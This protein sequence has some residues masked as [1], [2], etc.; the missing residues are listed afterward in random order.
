MASEAALVKR[1]Q[2]LHNSA[3]PDK[4]GAA[5][6]RRSS[7]ARVG[8][9]Y[10]DLGGLGLNENQVFA[11]AA[12]AR[13]FGGH[14]AAGNVILRPATAADMWAEP[15]PNDA[16]A[17]AANHGALPGDLSRA[18]I[19]R[20]HGADWVY[21]LLTGYETPPPTLAAGPGLA[22]NIQQGR[23]PNLRL[24][25]GYKPMLV[26]SVGIGVRKSDGELLKKIN[27]G[28]A[29]IKQDGTL[30]SILAKWGLEE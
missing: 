6:N 12:N 2:I 19:T 11:F 30:K 25:K 10:G 4:S 28:L 5:G 7:G 23:F 15:Y 13:V 22:Y 29:K 24:V 16:V 27:D 1:R 9:R 3:T 26:G 20:A 18:T 14:D 8:V 17:R 21:G